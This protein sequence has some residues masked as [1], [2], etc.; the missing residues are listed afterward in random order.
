MASG[1]TVIGE[2]EARRVQRMLARLYAGRLR[3]DEAIA[4]TGW[5]EGDWL[6]VCWELAR[7]DRSLIYPVECRLDLKVGAI[8]L[9]RARDLIY[10][11][12]G[13]FFGEYLIAGREPF[14]GSRWEEVAFTDQVLHVR[15]VERNDA[16]ERG[17][18]ELLADDAR[19][20]SDLASAAE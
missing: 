9:T 3:A 18:D 4:V 13:H 7:A 14:T 5:R 20:Q 15:G 19:D 17:A 10:D 1:Q 11:F 16:A 12:L 8:E 6:C 2:Y